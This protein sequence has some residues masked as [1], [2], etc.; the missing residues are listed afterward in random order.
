MIKNI[1]NPKKLINM[2]YCPQLIT[3]R[4]NLQK[5]IYMMSE[6]YAIEKKV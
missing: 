2:S 1:E 4:T 6:T 3:D 5:Q